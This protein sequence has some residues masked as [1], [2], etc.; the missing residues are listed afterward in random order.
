MN[1]FAIF[2][3]LVMCCSSAANAAKLYKIV[4]EKGN[5][6][7]SQYPPQETTKAA[8]VEDLTINSNSAATQLTSKGRS[9]Y[10]GDI[11]LLRAP[12]SQYSK[13]RFAEKLDRQQQRWQDDMQRLN[14]DID[15]MSRNQFNRSHNTRNYQNPN[16][17]SYQSTRNANYQQ[18]LADKTARLRDLRCALKWA[19]QRTEQIP[20]TTDAD[21]SAEKNR[22][23]GIKQEL[24]QSLDRVCGVLP[25]FDPTDKVAEAKRKA[26]YKCSSDFRQKI[27]LVERKINQL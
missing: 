1:R 6:S 21:L 13:Q 16:A 14:R 25:P 4:D 22:L 27:S 15:Q 9:Q 23:L 10:C 3:L 11:S 20:E 19:K 26:W 18:R 7:F 12:S 17:N 8:N 5:V 24:Q 2:A